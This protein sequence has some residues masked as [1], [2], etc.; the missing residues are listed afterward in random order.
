MELYFLKKANGRSFNLKDFLI[1]L[2]WLFVITYFVNKIYW[3][4]STSLTPINEESSF[5]FWNYLR[6]GDNNFLYLVVLAVIIAIYIIKI[7]KL[8][9]DGLDVRIRIII[10]TCIFLLAWNYTLY[11]YNYFLGHWSFSDRLLLC[12]V[13]ILAIFNPAFLIFVVIQSLVLSQQFQYPLFFDYSFTDKSIVFDIVIVGWLFIVIKKTLYKAIPEYLFYVIV[14]GIICNWY[15]L[16]GLGKLELNWLSKNELYKLFMVTLDYNWLYFLEWDTKLYIANFLK[17]YND[18]IQVTTIVVEL[19]FPIIILIHKR[20]SIF[21]L[22]SFILFHLSVFFTSGIF[23]WKWIVVELVI[24]LC[25]IKY[26]D[27]WLKKNKIQGILTYLVFLITANFYFSSSKLSWLDVGIYNKYEFKVKNKEG[28]VFNLESSFFSPYDL[29]FAQNRFNFIN[30]NKIITSTF[31]SALDENLLFLKDKANIL[32]Y[33]DANGVN[34]YNANK[35]KDLIMFIKTFINN[36]QKSIKF[37]L[38][39]APTH[40]WQGENQSEE[41]F[42]SELDSLFIITKFRFINEKLEYKDLNQDIIKISIN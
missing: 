33:V 39:N 29:N 28:E 20:I 2:F 34:K 7:K 18:V 26:K 19:I 21:V 23:F 6:Y 17:K 3:F 36:K 37:D 5:S 41:I 27:L 31:G 1:N 35:K 25:L 16:A 9:W 32:K 13:L 12:I 11:D 15:W 10:Y 8:T 38:P 40:I 14:L 4:I 30:N 42:K 24:I 22:G